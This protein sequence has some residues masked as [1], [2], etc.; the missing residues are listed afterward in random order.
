[1]G[2]KKLTTAN[3]VGDHDG[4]DG[5]HCPKVDCPTRPSLKL[6]MRAAFM[7]QVIVSVAVNCVAS[8]H[9]ADRYP[10]V[11]GTLPCRVMKGKVRP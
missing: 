10:T 6:G 1:M 8:L 4:L 3:S 7:K 11:I 9:L 2:G 5:G